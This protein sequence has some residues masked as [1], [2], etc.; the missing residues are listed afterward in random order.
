MSA[1][2]RGCSR[3]RSCWWRHLPGGGRVP[4]LGALAVAAADVA[5]LL[6][7]GAGLG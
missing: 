2:G 1:Y 6:V 4:F 3:S 5:L 7:R